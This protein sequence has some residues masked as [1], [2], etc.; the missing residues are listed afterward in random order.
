MYL[1]DFISMGDLL[2]LSKVPIDIVR[3]LQKKSIANSP[4]PRAQEGHVASFKRGDISWMSGR[5][6]YVLMCRIVLC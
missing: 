6:E 5:V 3:F 2:G 1:L 4:I